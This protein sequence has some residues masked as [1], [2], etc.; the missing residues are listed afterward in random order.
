MECLFAH[1]FYRMDIR[2][3]MPHTKASFMLVSGHGKTQIAT[4]PAGANPGFT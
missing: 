1:R 4:R 3:V 2:L